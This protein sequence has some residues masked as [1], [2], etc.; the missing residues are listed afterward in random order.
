MPGNREEKETERGIF[1]YSVGSEGLKNCIL[2]RTNGNCR[3]SFALIHAK[4]MSKRLNLTGE[5]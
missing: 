2:Y 1:V 3:Y 4:N 5:K